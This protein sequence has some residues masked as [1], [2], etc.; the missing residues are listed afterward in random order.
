MF[1]KIG[2]FVKENLSKSID[3]NSLDSMLNFFVDKNIQ[4]YIDDSSNYKNDQAEYL[5]HKEFSPL[6]WKDL[7][8]HT[9][10]AL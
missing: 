5:S 9:L 2:I 7:R 10:L 1:N 8:H 3:E 6:P 4:L